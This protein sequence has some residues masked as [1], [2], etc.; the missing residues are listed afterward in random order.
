LPFLHLLFGQRKIVAKIRRS[1]INKDVFMMDKLF[2]KGQKQNPLA[3]TFYELEQLEDSPFQLAMASYQAMKN[4]TKSGEELFYYM[5]EDAMFSSIYATY[6]EHLMSTMYQHQNHALALVEKFSDDAGEREQ[7]IA[8]QSQNHLTFI[9]NFGMC[10]GCSSCDN[11]KDVAQLIAPFQKG[12][13]NFFTELYIGMQTIQFT[14]EFLLYEIIPTNP[15][16]IKALTPENI[17]HLRQTIYNYA[18]LRASES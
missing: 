7:S 12:D 6:F 13:I 10:D 17:L 14:M 15:E 8:E 5:I 3:Q 9:E 1:A 18:Q 16:L 2:K 4:E 11:H